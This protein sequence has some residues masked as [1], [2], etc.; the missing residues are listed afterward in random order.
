MAGARPGKCRPP[1]PHP[2]TSVSQGS[3]QET[4]T[5]TVTNTPAA[6]VITPIPNRNA[7]TGLRFT[8][9][10]DAP[11]NPA[12]TFSLPQKPAGMAINPSTGIIS[13]TPAA[14][15]SFNV[16]IRAANSQG[17]DQKSFTVT[18]AEPQRLFLPLIR[19]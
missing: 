15:G 6:P 16:T 7:A 1:F 5:V 2:I 4:F 13:W 9:D 18:V 12:P 17:D 14:V 10:V 3:D 8:Y 11:G 19:Q